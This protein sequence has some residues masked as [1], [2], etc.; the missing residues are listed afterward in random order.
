MTPTRTRSFLVKNYWQQ[1]I[2]P[3]EFPIL[4][5]ITI[6]LWETTMIQKI[7]C[8]KGLFLLFF[9]SFLFTIFGCVSINVPQTKV[10]KSQSVEFK[11][12]GSG[13]KKVSAEDVDAAW[14]SSKTGNSISF[15]SDCFMIPSIRY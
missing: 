3:K 8:F 9:S 10:E 6:N 1:L 4:I 5:L 12:P 13:F 14:R 7:R 2:I 11:K 15:I